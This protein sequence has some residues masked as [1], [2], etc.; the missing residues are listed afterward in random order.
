MLAITTHVQQQLRRT[1]LNGSMMASMMSLHS[2]RA[3]EDQEAA[4]PLTAP[5]QSL[6]PQQRSSAP[7]QGANLQQRPKVAAPGLSKDDI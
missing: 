7:R 5:R 1:S 2:D 6:R 4:S 3:P